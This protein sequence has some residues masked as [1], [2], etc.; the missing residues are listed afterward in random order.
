[1]LTAQ[2][3]IYAAKQALF[4]KHV[5]SFQIAVGIDREAY[6]IKGE[7]TVV[8]FNYELGHE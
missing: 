8:R 6:F 1:M 5:Q 4:I 7:L 2:F 3:S